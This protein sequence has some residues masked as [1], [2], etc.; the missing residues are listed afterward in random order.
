LY[1]L[2]MDA[3]RLNILKVHQVW[4]GAAVDCLALSPSK[5]WMVAASK[6]GGL[7]VVDLEQQVQP[8]DT[9]R[10]IILPAPT[11]LAD[12]QWPAVDVQ[13]QFPRY[14]K[15]QLIIWQ[16]CPPCF[17]QL[18]CR[19]ASPRCVGDDVSC[20]QYNCGAWTVQCGVHSVFCKLCHGALWDGRDLLW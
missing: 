10:S 3:T 5:R 4:P 13:V 1:W 9:L 11:L 17:A 8:L 18:V 7:V 16:R 14:S 20:G 12:E 15:D 6:S 19:L 2:S